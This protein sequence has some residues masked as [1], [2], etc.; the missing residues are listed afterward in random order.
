MLTSYDLVELPTFILCFLEILTIAPFP[1]DIIAPVCHL[2]SQCTPYD[3]STHQMI[4][5][6][7]SAVRYRFM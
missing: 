7:L 6:K 5:F 4:L 1:I 3:P 2:E